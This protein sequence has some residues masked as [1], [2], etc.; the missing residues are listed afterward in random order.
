MA[1]SG[2]LL[3]NYSRLPCNE[4]VVKAIKDLKKKLGVITEVTVFVRDSTHLAIFIRQVDLHLKV[5]SVP[6]LKMKMVI[7]EN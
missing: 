4:I 1:S 2:K 5:G 7:G 6:S 3:R